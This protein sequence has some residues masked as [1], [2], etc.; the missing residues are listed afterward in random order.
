MLAFIPYAFS[1]LS[2]LITTYLVFR[3]EGREEGQATNARIVKLEAEQ[4]NQIQR[5]TGFQTEI[6]NVAD[7][8]K[9][10]RQSLVDSNK[11]EHESIRELIKDV[12]TMRELLYRM[13]ERLEN[14]KE[15]NIKLDHKMD[16]IV[17]LLTHK[18]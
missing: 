7:Y 3:K 10:E 18:N 5:Q 9:R 16:R 15:T 1:L 6:E 17:E 14:V 12:P 11:R 2:L 4:A 13:V 8:G